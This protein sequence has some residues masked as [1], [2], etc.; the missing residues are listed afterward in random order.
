VPHVFGQCAIGV[1]EDAAV[2]AQTRIDV[3]RA[4]A[5]RIDGEVGRQGERPLLEPLGAERFFTKWLIAG[6]GVRRPVME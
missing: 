1:F 2:V 6:P 5:A 3:A 4:A